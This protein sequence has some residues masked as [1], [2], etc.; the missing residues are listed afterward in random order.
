M[1]CSITKLILTRNDQEK[2]EKT[3]KSIENIDGEVIVGD[4]ESTDKT[5]AIATSLGAK[6]VK[7][8]WTKSYADGWN[9][10]IYSANGFIFNL[11]PGEVLV[12]NDDE[13]ELDKD[14]IYGVSLI[15]GDWIT[16][17]TRIWHTDLEIKYRNRVFE[18]TN[19]EY[20]C[21]SQITITNN[22]GKRSSE[23]SSLLDI[24]EKEDIKSPKF[25]YYKAMFRL[26]LGDI[27]GF[28]SYAHEYLFRSPSITDSTILIWL[29]LGFV[30]IASGNMNK[31]TEWAACILGEKPWLAEAWCMAAEAAVK[32]NQPGRASMLYKMAIA[33]GKWRPESDRMPI[34][35]GK[36][37]D[38][39]NEYIKAFDSA[40]LSKLP[41]NSNN[42]RNIIVEPS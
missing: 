2:I 40:V 24:W 42:N 30:E 25:S 12:Y 17:T 21:K 20:N 31:A 13:E 23:T 14:K 32:S 1:S 27:K 38:Q 37:R 10:L 15:T 4:M 8:P 36:Y 22:S 41:R 28:R 18:E 33:A 34:D 26:S 11:T 5:V 7:I 9:K 19:V 6:I 29:Y 3:L 16:Y 39:P 35:I